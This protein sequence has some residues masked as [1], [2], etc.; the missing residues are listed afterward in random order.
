MPRTLGDYRDFC[1]LLGEQGA[2]AT[3]FFDTKIA[4]SKK[5][6]EEEVIAAESQMFFLISSLLTPVEE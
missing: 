3:S 6:R 2:R 4:E 1:A 5:G